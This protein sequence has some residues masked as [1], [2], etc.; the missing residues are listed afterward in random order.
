MSKKKLKIE[1]IK[2][3]PQIEKRN[4]IKKFVE[5]EHEIMI[6]TVACFMFII[7]IAIYSNY[8]AIKYSDRI[9]VYYD[10]GLKV[11]FNINLEGVADLITLTD[12][13]IVD[14]NN[15]KK[16]EYEFTV[17]NESFVKTK[18]L[19]YIEEDTELIKIDN[20]KDK[21]VNL[22]ALRFSIN[23]GEELTLEEL[24]DDMFS[25]YKGNI[26]ANEVKYYK[27]NVWIDKNSMDNVNNNHFHGKI[28]ITNLDN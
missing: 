26:K 10:N 7:C 15:G 1:D 11:K 19:V 24:S 12:E 4:F 8:F 5:H 17:S 14:G 23:D 20:C 18:F 6:V 13:N 25:L 27:L 9:D 21:Q 28:I 22:D 3:D 16:E 2:K